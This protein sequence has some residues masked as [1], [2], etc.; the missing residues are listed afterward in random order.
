MRRAKD[1]IDQLMAERCRLTAFGNLACDGQSCA[2]ALFRYSPL[3][4]GAAGCV[5][6]N[7]PT[8]ATAASLG[9]LP[10]YPSHCVVVCERCRD[11]IERP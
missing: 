5:F 6:C 11:A 7:L 9:K 8:A 10:T 3:D 1:D 4:G 2:P